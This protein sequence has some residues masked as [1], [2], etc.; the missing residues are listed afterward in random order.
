MEKIYLSIIIPAYNE[1]KR[2][3]ATLLDIDRYLSKQKYSYEILVINDGSKDNTV[4]VVEKAKELIKNLIL[5]DNKE[6]HG[7]GWVTKQGMLEAKGEYRIYVDADNAIS[8][9]QIENFWSLITPEGD[10][11][12]VIG[13]IEAKG[14][15]VEENA[16]WYRRL[17]GKISKYIIRIIVG[18]WE[19]KDSQ[20]AF[21]LFPEKVVN[22]VFPYLKIDRWLFDVEILVLVKKMGYRIKEIPVQWINSG[23]SKV[24]LV[25]YIRSFW[26]LFKIKWNLIFDKYKIKKD[27]NGKI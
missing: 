25:S 19:I 16:G 11:D 6:N 10:Y 17:F 18:I 14:A 20:R 21:K 12:V 13:S 4:Q 8:M 5:I 23:E 9:D 2:I 22:D 27:V 15:K 3:S 1:A 7:K 24:G 26:D